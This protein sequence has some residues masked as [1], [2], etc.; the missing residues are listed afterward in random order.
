MAENW[1]HILITDKR[2]IV[3]GSPVTRSQ[4]SVLLDLLSQPGTD[5]DAT[6]DRLDAFLCQLRATGQYAPNLIINVSLRSTSG[7]YVTPD[8]GLS[9]RVASMLVTAYRLRNERG[10]KMLKKC[11]EWIV[12]GTKT[13]GTALF[14]FLSLEGINPKA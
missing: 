7:V 3:A 14:P 1:N 9:A 6:I 12:L 13:T 5:V 11:C 10:M 2:Q 8:T 4:A